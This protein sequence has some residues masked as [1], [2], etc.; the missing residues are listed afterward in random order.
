MNVM[1]LLEQTDR[2]LTLWANQFAGRSIVLDKFVFDT[3]DA[4]LLNSGVVLAAYWWLW[5][6]ADESGVCAQRRNVVVA[7]LAVI[8]VATAAWLLKVL[9]AL[10]PSSPKQ[11]RLRSPT[12][13]RR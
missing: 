8:V 2:A 5:F 13:V 7:L 1:T 9:L 3:L 11:P 10:P 6:E 4:S 12:A